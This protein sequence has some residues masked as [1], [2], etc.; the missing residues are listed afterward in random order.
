MVNIIQS[1]EAYNNNILRYMD[2]SFEVV[3]Y[4]VHQYLTENMIRFSDDFNSDNLKSILRLC[5]FNDSDINIINTIGKCQYNENLGTS[6]IIPDS[7]EGIIF[8]ELIQ[9]FANKIS[10]SEDTYLKYKREKQE[11]VKL[12]INT[13]NIDIKIADNFKKL[14]DYRAQI[15]LLDKFNFTNLGPQVFNNTKIIKRYDAFTD[16]LGH[17]YICY[18][19]GWKQFTNIN[20]NTNIERIPIYLINFQNTHNN[21]I[22]ILPHIDILHPFYKHN[23]NII[24]TYF[25]NQRYIEDNKVLGFVYDLLIVPKSY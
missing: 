17:N 2:V 3:K 13:N 25:E 5:N 20:N 8:K 6:I 14:T 18:M 10:K 24:K 11:L 4:I 16:T 23:N 21:N 19:E 15:V 1:N 7:D 9:D 22:N 12:G